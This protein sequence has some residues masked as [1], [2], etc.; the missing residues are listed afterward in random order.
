M[1]AVARPLPIPSARDPAPGDDGDLALEAIVSANVGH[2]S[3]APA[4]QRQNRI[5]G[6]QN[7]ICQQA[8]VRGSRGSNMHCSGRLRDLGKSRGDL[9][10]L[11]RR[12]P[13][14]LDGRHAGFADAAESSASRRSGSSTA[15][16]A[17]SCRQLQTASGCAQ[18]STIGGAHNRTNSPRGSGNFFQD[19]ICGLCGTAE[20]TARRMAASELVRII[21][22]YFLDFRWDRRDQ[23]PATTVKAGELV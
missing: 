7:S 11:R 17:W 14:I 16:T 1:T 4:V 8:Q 6:V 23:L 18:R 15:A 5:I 9:G 13:V 21:V 3:H 20:T 10:L 2:S 22:T 19:Q 12:H